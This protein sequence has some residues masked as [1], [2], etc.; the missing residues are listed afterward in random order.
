M[1]VPPNN[2]CY[3]YMGVTNK[4]D[5]KKDEPLIEERLHFFSEQKRHCNEYQVNC[6]CNRNR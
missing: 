5:V 2:I 6:G 3:M 4:I 1:F